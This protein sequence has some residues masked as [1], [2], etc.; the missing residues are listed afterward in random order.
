MSLLAL[1]TLCKY[2]KD[3]EKLSF[4]NKFTGWFLVDHLFEEYKKTSGKFFTC[5][6][7]F[8]RLILN[9]CKTVR[10]ITFWSQVI[11]LSE[12][13]LLAIILVGLTWVMVLQLTR[14]SNRHNFVDL[15]FLYFYVSL[16]VLLTIKLYKLFTNYDLLI[17]LKILVLLFIIILSCQLIYLLPLKIHSLITKNSK[18]QTTYLKILSYILLTGF[19]TI[20]FFYNLFMTNDQNNNFVIEITTTYTLLNAFKTFL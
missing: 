1:T 8:R 9:L 12:F 4:F 15:I 6:K 11:T 13:M 16:N 19:L 2:I 14:K 5:N 18:N 3:K 7:D 10:N 20:I 17:I